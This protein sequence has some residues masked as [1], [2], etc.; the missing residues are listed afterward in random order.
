MGVRCFKAQK[1]RVAGTPRCAKA[2]FAWFAALAPLLALGGCT[3]MVSGQNKAQSTVQVTPAAVDFGNPG[4]GKVVSHVATVTNTGAA[5]VT[6]SKASVSTKEFSI[7]GLQFPVSIQAGQK[8]RFTVSFKG[9]KPGKVKGQ[10]HFT[11]DPTVPDPVD[12]TGSAGSPAPKLEISAASHD[13]G[14]VTVN[15]VANSTLTLTNS[16]AGNLNISQINATGATFSVTGVSVPAVVPAGGTATLNVSFSPKAAGN[17]TG[18]MAIASD[19]PTTPNATVSLTGVGTAVDVGKLTATPASLSFSNVKVGSSA[20]AVS[21]LKNT[22]T[23]NLTLSQ[24]ST[25]TAV[26]STSGI[27]APVVMA[28]GDSLTLTVKFAP[29]AAGAKSDSVSLVN[30]QG[31][32][33]SVSLSG[34]AV[35]SSLTVSPGNINFG[36]VV[37]NLTNSQTVQ[38]TNPSTISV[39]VSA[40]NITG[41]GFSTSGLALPLTLNGGQSSTFNVLFAP[42]T[43]AASSGTL[44]LVSDAATSPAPITLSGTGIAAGSTLSVN[45]SSLGFGNVKVGSSATAVTTLK[46]T[47]T[48]NITLSQI[49]TGTTVYSTSGITAPVVMAPGDSLALTVKFA[50][51]TSGTKSD[52]VSLLDSLG[53]ITSVSLS[54][55]AVQ[56]S[57][58]VSPGNI[59]F[60]NVVTNLTNSQTVQ[61]TN[62]SAISVK[63]TAANITGTGFGTSGLN[64]P[65][66]L[67]AGQSSTFNV[68]FAPNTAAASSGTR[69]WCPTL[70]FRRPP[71]RWRGRAL[72]QDSHC[73]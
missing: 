73:R 63:V 33:T 50:P 28:P 2:L 44:T 69:H 1:S 48:A 49:S 35:Q 9:S 47:G 7:S 65:L 41:T 14:K 32:I 31:G 68:Q 45:P 21:T 36:N 23:A 15:T 56:S 10:L 25:G 55:T 6:L 12:L 52:S 37:T 54:G 39:K 72:P 46:N 57:L 8:A 13:F 5:T 71:S 43:A 20:T 58:T 17:F 18:T 40:A 24:I 51:T 64:L 29:T 26:Y 62:P 67:N 66:T 3:G 30:S 19:D 38:I 11:G 53:G 4:V 42:K 16:G 34:T 27:T 22:G 60:G 70:R 59:N 61:V